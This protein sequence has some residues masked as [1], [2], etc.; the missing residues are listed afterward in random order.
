MN[1]PFYVKGR[2]APSPTGRM[3]LGNIAT[4]LISWLSAK[5]QG[6]T[7]LL[8]IEDLDRS[9]SRAGYSRL[10]EDDLQWLGLHWDEGGLDDRGPHGPYSQSRRDDIYVPLLRRLADTGYLYPCSCTRAD[11]MAANAPHQSDGRVIYPGTCRP[12]T[13]P[14]PIGTL[15]PGKALRLAVP[16]MTIAFR[17][18]YCGVQSFNLARDC[19]DFIV[20]RADG[21]LAYQL[22][23]VIDDALMGVTEVVRGNDLLLSAAQQIHIFNLLGFSPPRYGHTPLICN[24]EGQRLSKRDRSLSMDSLRGRLTA[25]QIIGMAAQL[26]GLQTAPDP[27]TPQELLNIYDP[28]KISTGT[29][30][31]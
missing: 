2:F 25:P 22:A 1:K 31:I 18:I 5:S 4:A 29:S 8:R 14:V 13:L 27:V 11:I 30:M 23:V 26:T 28:A 7:W 21:T 12:S 15:P 10:I 17:D 3:H 20:R 6:G 9:R 16:D 24:S 19:G